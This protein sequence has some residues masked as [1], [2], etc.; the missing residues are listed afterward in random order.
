MVLSEEDSIL[1]NF[2]N[3]CRYYILEGFLSLTPH[4]QYCFL[5]IQLHRIEKWKKTYNLKVNLRYR[6]SDFIKTN[7]VSGMNCVSFNTLSYYRVMHYEKIT[8][9][10]FDALIIGASTKLKSKAI[11][12][13]N[14]LQILK[15]DYLFN[16]WIILWKTP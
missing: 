14:S 16:D 9:L 7:V 11:M 8:L 10:F 5:I 13:W 12:G 2:Q 3:I 15:E 6:C 1:K 4:K